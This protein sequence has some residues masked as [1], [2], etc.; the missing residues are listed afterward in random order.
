MR[1][2]IDNKKGL[3]KIGNSENYSD[4]I[5]SRNE[6]EELLLRVK[7]AEELNINLK[8]ICRER[9]CRKAGKPKDSSGYFVIS[10][11]QTVEKYMRDISFD[12]WKKENPGVH[13]SV[14][15]SPI[16][17]EHKVWKSSIQT[18]HDASIT[19]DIAEQLVIKDLCSHVF[20][21]LGIDD[22]QDDRENGVYPEQISDNNKIARNIVY[23]WSFK[24]DFRI[25]FWTFECYHTLPLKVPESLRL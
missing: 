12:D 3:L 15:R 1:F 24:A 4:V 8:R 13:S 19:F 21:D 9:A 11:A 18:P 2:A 5:M 14:Y 22:M 20:S 7:Y 23:R 25:G 10:S 6:Y 16:Q 17:C